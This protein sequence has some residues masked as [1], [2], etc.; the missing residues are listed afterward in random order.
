MSYGGVDKYNPAN[1]VVNDG[2]TAF[3]VMSTT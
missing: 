3:A 1:K 2:D